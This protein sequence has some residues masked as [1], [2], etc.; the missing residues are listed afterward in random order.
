M[1]GI[2]LRATFAPEKQ[3]VVAGDAV[4]SYGDLLAAA[5]RLAATLVSSVGS[6]AHC[7]PAAAPPPAEAPRSPHL[8]HGLT[9]TE[10]GG[11]R[12]AVMAAPGAEYAAGMYA[13]WMAGGVAVPLALSHPPAELDHVLGDASVAA[14][15]CTQ[16][17]AASLRPV[18]DGRSVPLLPLD[19]CFDTPAGESEQAALLRAAAWA[20]AAAGA[21]D[22]R[23]ALIIYTSGTTGR[24]KGAVHSHGGLLA[25]VRSLY[26]AWQWTASDRI[27]HCLP[28]HH[29]H[30]I[31]NAWM[32]C[33][34]AG[35][36]AEF[37]PKFSTSG[38]WARVR[39]ASQPPITVFMGVPTMYV[40]LL[41]AYDKMGEEE[42]AASRAAAGRLRL[43]V[44]G[45][46]AC[47]VSV[48]EQ[49][50][51]LSGQKLLERYGMTEIGM[52]LSNPLTPAAAR[53]P[54]WVG[55]PLPGLEVR[56]VP[57]SEEGEGE[58]E[59]AA[60]GEQRGELRVRGPGVFRC[61]IGQPEATAASFDD[62]GFFKTGDAVAYCPSTG[63]YRILGRSSVDIIKSGGYKLSALEI[64]SALL[65]HP[66]IGECAVVGMEHP[67]LGQEVGVV[68]SAKSGGPPLPT[69]KELGD[70]A[71]DHL[72][73][74]KIPKRMV[75]VD[76]VPRN[77]MGKV[78]KVDLKKQYFA[79]A[80]LPS[81]M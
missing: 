55:T 20:E 30:G 57:F 77:A 35:A 41:S 48:H 50:E 67:T 8:P 13:V 44:C 62:D 46:A 68:V 26:Q 61:Y 65:H 45:S 18:A 29:I 28:L 32:C 14:A 59:A 5:G 79:A 52:A 40:Y 63:A 74:Y 60:E 56:V 38:W 75:A 70:W 80:A 9:G 31:V 71:K 51:A 19:G 66:G 81:Q 58:V 64:E 22:S 3:A 36:T 10:L 12:V 7:D 27:L 69:L 76:A 47:P 24:P 53:R 2:L 17:Y 72:A 6:A 49:W 54:G 39:D 4:R 11:R 78:N 73:P 33:M 43:T 37:A 16:Q 25:E 42:Q 1:A 34:Y 15:L 23:G 21:G